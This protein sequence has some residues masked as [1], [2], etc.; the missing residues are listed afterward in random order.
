M[1]MDASNSRELATGRMPAERDV[2]SSS[3]ASS[4]RNAIHN[5]D[6]SNSRDTKTEGATATTGVPKIVVTLVLG[7]PETIRATA[8]MPATVRDTSK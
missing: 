4:S 7:T 3:D 1:G 5:R 8:E 6:G 2:S